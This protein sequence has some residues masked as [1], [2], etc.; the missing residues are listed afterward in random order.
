M[1]LDEVVWAPPSER[2]EAGSPNII[3]AI[4]LVTAIREIAA[5]PG[6]GASGPAVLRDASRD[7]ACGAAAA[8]T[9]CKRQE[10][11]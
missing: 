3:G 7:L 4:A 11:G 10:G 1:D 6:R 5:P 8:V 9:L 2:E